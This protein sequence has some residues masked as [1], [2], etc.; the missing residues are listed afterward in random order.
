[1]VPNT[2]SSE[3]ISSSIGAALML[4]RVEASEALGESH[5]AAHSTHL[6]TAAPPVR[7]T[8]RV[9]VGTAKGTELRAALGR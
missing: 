7:S 8:A 3:F 4:D 9:F 2:C 6:A 1:M 5:E